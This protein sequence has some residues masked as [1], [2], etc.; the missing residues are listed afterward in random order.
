MLHNQSVAPALSPTAPVMVALTTSFVVRPTMAV[1]P[2]LCPPNWTNNNTIDC[3]NATM[4]NAVGM[5]GTSSSFT[6]FPGQDGAVMGY[7][8]NYSLP[9]DGLFEFGM[10]PLER[11]VSTIAP[12]FFGIIGLAGLLGNALVILEAVLISMRLEDD[13]KDERRIR[14]NSAHL[15]NFSIVIYNFV[16]I[17]EN[18]LFEAVTLM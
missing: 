13:S 14:V 11:V 10:D 15:G 8:G 17:Y 9:R 16:Y 5:G 7:D 18:D 2:G 3:I 12:V 6:G 1:L 4:D